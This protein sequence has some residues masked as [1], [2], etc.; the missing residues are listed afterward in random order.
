MWGLLDESC[1]THAKQ[2]AKILAGNTERRRK[3]LLLPRVAA[4]S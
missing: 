1:F 2:P 3:I 4:E